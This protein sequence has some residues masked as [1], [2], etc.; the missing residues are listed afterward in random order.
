M[1]R[2]QGSLNLILIVLKKIHCRVNGKQEINFSLDIYVGSFT[3]ND[4]MI[5]VTSVLL[6][7][8]FWLVVKLKHPA[9]GPLT[10]PGAHMLVLTSLH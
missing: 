4:R 1:V 6:Y 5:K 2:G 9:F 10:P 3:H 8:P 7:L